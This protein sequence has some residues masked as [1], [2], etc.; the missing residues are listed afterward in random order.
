[1]RQR[2]SHFASSRMTLAAVVGATCWVATALLFLRGSRD[3]LNLR[4]AFLHMAAD[5]A[6]SAGVVVAGALS[7]WFAW[8]WLDPVVSLLIAVLIVAG[9]WRLFRQ[10]LHLLFDGVPEALRAIAARGVKIAVVSSNAEGNVRRALGPELSALVTTWSCGA[11]LFGKAKHFRDVLRAT[12]V[13]PE[14]ALSIGDEIRD[15]EAR[16]AELGE[17]RTAAED[18]LKRIDVRAPQT[19]I[20]HELRQ[21]ALGHRRAT[22]V[23]ETHEADA[24]LLDGH[25]SAQT[26]EERLLLGE[27]IA[28]LELPRLLLGSRFVQRQLAVFFEE[29]EGGKI[30]VSMRSK[31]RRLDVCKIALAFGGGCHALAAGIRMSGPLEDAKKLVLAAIHGR[32]AEV[33]AES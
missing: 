15:I 26:D 24:D 11:G 23:A 25:D 30:R 31:D 2:A 20:V 5:A 7:L 4:G 3:D 32:I 16:V 14:R 1:M 8:G 33:A 18:Q 27:A 17:R 12:K 21:H 22:D 29:L 13:A 10:S 9:T 28:Q 19:G 6:V